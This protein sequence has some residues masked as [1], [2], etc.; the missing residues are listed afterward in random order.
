MDQGQIAEHHGLQAHVAG[1]ARVVERARK[2][3][4][5][6]RE[7]LAQHEPVGPVGRDV[8]GAL[9]VA[10]RL[11]GVERGGEGGVGLSRLT[12]Q[13]VAD[14]HGVAGV[15]ARGRCRFLDG[16]RLLR[17]LDHKGAVAAT[18]GQLRAQ[19]QGLGVALPVAGG[20]QFSLGPGQ[21]LGC[22]V[23]VG[24]RG[25]QA[26]F[27][28]QEVRAAIAI[29]GGEG[30]DPALHA[31]GAAGLELAAAHTDRQG[32]GLVPI[33]RAEQMLH[34]LPMVAVPLVVG[35]GPAVQAGELRRI[36]GAQARGEEAAEEGMDPILRRLAHAH[37]GEEEL[38]VMDRLERLAAAR[39]LQRRFA[40][41]RGEMG[42][43]RGAQQE[44]PHIGRLLFKHFRGEVGIQLLGRGP[45][46]SR[47]ACGCL[48]IRPVIQP[49]ARARGSLGARGIGE[50]GAPG[51]PAGAL[52]RRKRSASAPSPVTC[53][54]TISRL[55]VMAGATRALITTWAWGGR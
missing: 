23:I 49:S 44:A 52:L 28:Q 31:L 33:L 32:R 11:I 20:Q 18:R 25:Q 37:R 50:H 15:R 46:R 34:R 22:G 16:Q 45:G 8:R 26:G 7:L 36:V 24:L 17:D 47:R 14:G 10:E 51:Q 42:Q 29:G 19:A 13:G 38:P 3:R 27:E 35:R 40:H 5:R 12:G 4:Q 39:R 54:C 55:M 6:G 21:D 41:G 53:C 48:Q 43:D 1:L 2:L 30:A 9:H